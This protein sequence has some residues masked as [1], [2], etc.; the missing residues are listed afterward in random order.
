MTHPTK[1]GVHGFIHFFEIKH[2]TCVPAKIRLNFLMLEDHRV[3]L[4]RICG[5]RAVAEEELGLESGQID[6]DV[7]LEGNNSLAP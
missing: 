4:C 5:T 1:F 3:A 6:E 7:N 2:E